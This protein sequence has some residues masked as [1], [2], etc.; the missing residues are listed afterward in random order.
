MLVAV[1]IGMDELD[2][3]LLDACALTIDVGD[4]VSATVGIGG[5][6]WPRVKPGA[7]GIVIARVPGGFEVYFGGRDRVR[8]DPSQVCLL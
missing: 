2:G 3:C 1:A 5:F 7:R 6:F 4:R 8:V